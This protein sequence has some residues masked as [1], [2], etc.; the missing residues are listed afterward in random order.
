MP[1]RAGDEG[2]MTTVVT[3]RMLV[4]L[5]DE[6]VDLTGLSAGD[7]AREVAPVDA[8]ESL[9]AVLESMRTQRVARLP[10]VDDGLELG[11]ITRGD[12]LL[13]REVEEKLGA[14]I[15]D[16]V[17]DVSPN[18]KMFPGSLAVYLAERSLGGRGCEAC[19]GCRGQGNLRVDP[20]L[21]V[22]ARTGPAGPE[23]RVSASGPGRLRHRCGRSSFLRPGLRGDAAPLRTRI[24]GRST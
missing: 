24:P 2:R 17:V 14:K 5:R 3:Q 11:I 1:V 13:Y 19:P 7:V 9:D 21:R 6:G 22:R 15:T 23:G 10:V 8:G 4:D 18:D 20:R 12:V 16:L